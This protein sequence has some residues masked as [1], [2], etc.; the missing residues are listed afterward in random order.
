MKKTINT[1]TAGCL[2]ITLLCSFVQSEQ[3]F[4]DR[5]SVF[6]VDAG[7]KRIDIDILNMEVE[8]VLKIISD[9]SGWTI[10]PSQK[11]RGKVSLWSKGAT[12]KELLDTFCLVNNYVH[13]KDD[14]VI[15][16][17]TKEE[18]EGLF[19]QNSK[20]FY[21]ENQKAESIKQLLENSLTKT[22]R[23]SVDPWSNTVVVND[24]VEN[25]KKIESLVNRLDQGFVQK[26]FQLANAKA[27]E[28][29]ETLTGICP[30]EGPFQADARTNSIV[31][32]SSESNVERI[33][34][35]VDQLDQDSITRVFQIKFQKASELAAQIAPF[36]NSSA[37]AKETTTRTD[38]IIV[39][40]ETN[41]IVITG[42]SRQI[43]YIADIIAELDSK[44]I[45]T[46]IPLKHLKATEVIGQ[47]SHL[48]SRAE[49][50]TADTQG[51]QLIVR[52]NTNNVEQIQQVIR[53]LDKGLVTRVLALEYATA[54]DIINVLNTMVTNPD[55]FRAEPRTNQIV[56][57]DSEPQV[58]RIEKL[59][60]NLDREDAYFTRTYSLQHASASHVAGIIQSF[61]YRPSTQVA[62]TDFLKPQTNQISQ[63]PQTETKVPPV[64]TTS[65]SN[66]TGVSLGASPGLAATERKKEAVS[67][68]STP[69]DSPP[70]PP[71]Q[72]YPEGPASA[73][74]QSESKSLGT[75]GTVIPDD[76]SNTITI[77]ETLTTLAKIEQLIKDLDIPIQSYTYTVRFRQLES[78]DL[79]NKLPNFL[80]P[81]QDVYSIDEQ[82]NTVYF[83]TIPSMAQIIMDMFEKWD[84]PPKQALIQAKIIAVNTSV[85]KDFGINFESVFEISDVDIA[86]KGSLPSQIGD[87]A[88]SLTVQ[89]LTGTQFK[90]ILRAIESDS[91]SNILASPRILVIDGQ[92]AEV[93]MATDEPFS[94]TSIDA[95]NGKTIENVRFLQVG[96]ILMV[97]PNITEDDTIEMD[98]GLD[99][100]SLVE[101]RNGIPVVNHNIANTKV[102]VKNNHVLM[103]GGLKFKRD[104][105]VKE[106]IPILGDIPF[107]GPLFSSDRNE[108]ADSE[109]IL[110]LQPSIVAPWEEAKEDLYQV[111]P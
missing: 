47:V 89:H 65:K 49:N 35:I 67:A 43:E 51:N 36:L 58:A 83:T 16:I 50:I 17:M 108:H 20:T 90:A 27:T 15:Y 60:E 3:G 109:L 92:A 103:I 19:G 61:I 111:T 62:N 79:D 44:V 97:K 80:R 9:T 55:T 13:K 91:H 18:Y 1:F 105:R 59:I 41:Q 52:D 98:I 8:S 77:T 75:A 5:S 78:L 71:S 33:A 29:A 12:A 76:R 28:V 42:S 40:D 53:E 93:R 24:T 6:N 7:Q 74:E 39:S 22:G 37:E 66:R 110:L 73:T 69:T 85:L 64:D 86:A 102:V 10:I 94:E 46:T 31:V 68:G 107:L 88:G 25:L 104:L 26:R 57:C 81:E 63:Q 72:G 30:K 45:T 96:T 11:I 84:K 100:S 32:F 54:E 87:R 23:L 101:I 38:Q 106:K 34:R 4:N 99:V 14:N 95:D 70:S 82:T 2:L 56:I 48:A 21:L